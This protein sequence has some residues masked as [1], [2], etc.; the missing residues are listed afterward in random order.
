MLGSI[1]SSM[2]LVDVVLRRGGVFIG[3]LVVVLLGD[4][5]VVRL[6][7]KKIIFLLEL[8]LKVFLLKL[9]KVISSVVVVVSFMFIMLKEVDK[10]GK[11]GMEFNSIKESLEGGKLF[12]ESILDNI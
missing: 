7:F 10:F 5:I 11:I 2:V 12:N 9:V 4:I 8:K 6:C 1:D 3:V